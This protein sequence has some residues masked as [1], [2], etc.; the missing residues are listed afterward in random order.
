MTVS[1][2]HIHNKQ[3]E[4]YHCSWKTHLGGLVGQESVLSSLLALLVG[5]E[6]RK[7]TVVVTLHL[8]VEHL[9]LTGCGSWDEVVVQ[10]LQDVIANLSELFLD[11]RGENT[12]DT[13]GSW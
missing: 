10:E 11:L 5:L 13:Q 8:Q 1:Q 9:R 4:R 2:Q 12:A 3:Q 7:I 6:L